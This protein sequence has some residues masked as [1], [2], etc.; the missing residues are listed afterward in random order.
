MKY[1]I[2]TAL[3]GLALV[4]CVDKKAQTEVTAQQSETT[5]PATTAAA[6][7]TAT[8]IDQTAQANQEIHFTG[9]NDLTLTL[10]TTD[11]FETAE[12][13]DNSEEIRQLKRVIS[14][15]G[16]RLANDA[17]VSIHFKE[18]NGVNEG[19]VELVK[20]KPIEVKEFKAN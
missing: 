15:S 8:A 17:G 4:G 1:L 16:I 5:A 12:L 6:S 20:G 9:P 2:T 18:S 10:R 14:G 7:D 3:L 19:T 13:T 11:N